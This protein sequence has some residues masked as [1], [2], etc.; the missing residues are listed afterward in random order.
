M[1]ASAART[2]CCAGLS[3]DRIGIPFIESTPCPWRTGHNLLE[4]RQFFAYRCAFGCL[5]VRS[6]RDAGQGVRVRFPPDRLARRPANAVREIL[7][8]AKGRDPLWS[9]R[10][11]DIDHRYFERDE[12]RTRFRPQV[13]KLDGTPHMLRARVRCRHLDRGI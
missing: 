13:K 12:F 8:K 11:E 10:I 5:G 3:G 2:S 1:I 9:A 4:Q 6:R 7:G